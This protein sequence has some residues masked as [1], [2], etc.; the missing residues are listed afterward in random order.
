MILVISLKIDDYAADYQVFRQAGIVIG[1]RTAS[2]PC[3]RVYWGPVCWEALIK[4]TKQD[5]LSTMEKQQTFTDM[6][7]GQ[8]KRKSRRE[9]FLE[10][11]NRLVPWRRIEEQIRPHYFAG[12]RG[13]PPKRIQLMLRMYLPR[14]WFSLADGAA[15]EQIYGSY[16]MKK[17][18]GIDFMEEGAPD[19]AA[20]QS[21][22][23]QARPPR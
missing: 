2:T 12:K 10:T 9:I 19:A 5:K 4:V 17:F 1:K 8:R 18:M 21:I 3:G 6:E 20:I 13:R 22:T 14:V 16:A 11:M 7:Y 15:E 23:R